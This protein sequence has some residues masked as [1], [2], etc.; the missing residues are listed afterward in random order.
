M[1]DPRI[2]IQLKNIKLDFDKYGKLP[3]MEVLV[4][5]IKGNDIQNIINAKNQLRKIKILR[6]NLFALDRYIQAQTDKRFSEWLKDNGVNISDIV[7][8]KLGDYNN[9]TGGISDY[10]LNLQIFYDKG[11]EKYDELE[12]K[13]ILPENLKEEFEA[14]RKIREEKRK[15][16]KI[17]Q[18]GLFRD[19]KKD[20][21]GYIIVNLGEPE[22]YSAAS[23]EG[24]PAAPKTDTSQS[25]IEA[26]EVT[27]EVAT[28]V[29]TDIKKSSKKIA[30]WLVGSL[31]A[32]TVIGLAVSSNK[33]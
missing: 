28:E 27:P 3:K 30:I 31:I 16:R 14:N 1:S 8:R 23:P 33:K 21:K 29:K 26:K 11:E 24:K 9:K 17:C 19:L 20:E 10:F 15:I 32:V 25:D 18:K 13:I 4:S 22:T 7:Y 2:A 5:I 12:A 6:K